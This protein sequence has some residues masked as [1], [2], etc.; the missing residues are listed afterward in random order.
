M[1]TECYTS[2][3]LFSYADGMFMIMPPGLPDRFYPNEKTRKHITE[4]YVICFNPDVPENI[5]ERLIKDYSEYYHKK[6]EE[7]FSGIYKE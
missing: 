2:K 7:E 4:D 5:K 6:R 1:Y 3:P